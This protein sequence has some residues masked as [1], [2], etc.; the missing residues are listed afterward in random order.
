M[1]VP[2]TVALL[3]ALAFIWY[4]HEG[5]HR[6]LHC[7]VCGTTTRDHDDDCPWNPRG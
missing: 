2:Y 4:W 6:P 5:V 1:T 3:V 7:P